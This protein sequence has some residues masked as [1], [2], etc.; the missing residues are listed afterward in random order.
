MT[1]QPDLQPLLPAE[2]AHLKIDTANA[3]YVEAHAAA[4]QAG[5]SQAQFSALLGFEA[6][7]VV[8]R[9]AAA[10]APTS[11]APKLPEKIEGYD[12][13]SFAQKWQAGEARRNG[14][15]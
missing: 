7:A 12:K 3:R 2:Y 1:D 8:A 15:R 4:R 11:P 10:P 13:M 9:Q 5:L 6:K 14:G